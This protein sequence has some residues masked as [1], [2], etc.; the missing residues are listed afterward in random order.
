MFNHH[1]EI[2][3]YL[4]TEDFFKAF[5][6]FIS[7][8]GKPSDVLSDNGSNFV[9]AVNDLRKFLT[10]NSSSL[11]DSAAYFGIKWRFIPV[12]SPNFGGLWEASVKSV[13]S[14][15]KR[16]TG[17][18]SITYEDLSTWIIHIQGVLNSR[19]VSPLSPDPNDFT[20]L[21]S[22][23]FFL[24]RSMQ[25]IPEANFASLP[26]NRLS[27]YKFIYKLKQHFWERWSKKYISELQQTQ[28]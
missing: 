24:G 20:P 14:H 27:S 18:I 21:T 26:A 16:V 15:L 9:G 12:N 4:S 5:N 8:R 6:R 28:K 19:P 3:T 10:K 1:L 7:R 25:D 11:I 2:V 22:V 13:K 23:H 17:E